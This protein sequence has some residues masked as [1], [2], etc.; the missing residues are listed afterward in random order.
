RSAHPRGTHGTPRREPRR[1]R[2]SPDRSRPLGGVL[3][4]SRRSA[5]RR[6]RQRERA[7]ARVVLRSRGCPMNKTAEVVAL[8]VKELDSLRKEL[9]RHA[10]PP[11]WNV[12]PEDVQKSVVRR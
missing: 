11:R 7:V 9:Q 1:E 5:P 2:V 10:W 6:A 4:Q 8:Q 3:A 12:E